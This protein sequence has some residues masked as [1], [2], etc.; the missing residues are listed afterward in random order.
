MMENSSFRPVGAP[1]DAGMRSGGQESVID[2]ECYFEGT[3]RTPGNM[4]IEG[5]Y[6][7]VVECHGTL[8]IAETGQVNA[9]IVAGNLTVSGQLTGEV[10]CESRFELLN[11][12]RVSGSIAAKTSVIHDGA[13]FEGEIRMGG[14]EQAAARPAPIVTP[15]AAEPDAPTSPPRPAASGGNRRRPATETAAAS[16]ENAAADEEADAEPRANG[17]SDNATRDV[18]PNRTG[19]A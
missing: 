7:G 8:F 3:F 9:R 6:Q 14:R 13:F 19:E 1:G 15:P 2:Q 11:S 18:V 16:E 12:G 4:R 17:R 10:Q 5:T